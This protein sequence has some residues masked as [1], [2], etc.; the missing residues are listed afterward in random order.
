[1]SM[2]PKRSPE[3]AIRLPSGDQA[4]PLARADNP[5]SCTSTLARIPSPS[6]ADQSQMSGAPLL[7]DV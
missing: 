7:S 3:N 5:V 6:S 1:M 4:S 2:L